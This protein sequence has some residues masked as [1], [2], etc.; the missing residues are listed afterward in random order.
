MKINYLSLS[1]TCPCPVRFLEFSHRKL[2][3]EKNKIIQNRKK[4]TSLDKSFL[5]KIRARTQNFLSKKSKIKKV[6]F[7]KYFFKFRELNGTCA[8][9]PSSSS[10]SKTPTSPSSKCPP[11]PPSR[12]CTISLKFGSSS[13]SG[14]NPPLVTEMKIN[15]RRHF[16]MPKV[17]HLQMPIVIVKCLMSS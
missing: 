10:T 11:P 14:F 2:F 1:L 12:C 3:L 16:Q 6:F 17:C 9:W 8:A 13:C 7:G 5:V 4:K 15:L